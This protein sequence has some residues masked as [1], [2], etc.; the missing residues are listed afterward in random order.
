MA[1]F[2]WTTF[3]V[4]IPVKAS[5]EKLYWCWSARAGLEYWFLRMG[6]FKSATGVLRENSEELQPV[7]T[8]PLLTIHLAGFLFFLKLTAIFMKSKVNSS[9]L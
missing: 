7:D 3:T 9:Y 4:R 8:F 2:N 1:E 6:E 5:V